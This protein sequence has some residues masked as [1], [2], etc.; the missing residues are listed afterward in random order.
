[1]RPLKYQCFNTLKKNNF[2][3]RTPGGVRRRLTGKWVAANAISI[4]APRVG[5]DYTK[6]TKQH[7]IVPPISIHAPR[8]GCDS[9]F[10]GNIIRKIYIS[11]H[12]PRVGCDAMDAL[13]LIATELAISIHAPRVGCDGMTVNYNGK[14]SRISI[15]APRVGCDSDS[16]VGAGCAVQ[17]QSTHPGWGA[18]AERPDCRVL[19]HQFQSTHPGW[20]ATIYYFAYVSSHLL[21]Q[22]TH[23]G[24]GATSPSGKVYIGMTDFNPRTPGGVRRMCRRSLCVPSYFNPR[25]PGGVR[26]SA[27]R[28]SA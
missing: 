20:G 25:T 28:Q 9:C 10:N 14:L 23:P 27:R 8:V 3:P 4:H 12:A 2:N 7:S 11:I 22:S 5:C 15:H 6:T 21:F 16:R 18:T 24:W 26:L 13:L 19:I 1:M 17:F